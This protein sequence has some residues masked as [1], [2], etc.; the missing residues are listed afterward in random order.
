MWAG[1]TTRCSA[2]GAGRV[3]EGRAAGDDV[4]DARVGL[5]DVDAQMQRRVG[6][7]IQVHEQH[8]LSLAGQGRR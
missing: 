8:V 4:V 5:A 2:T 3:R 7:R 1:T 6:L